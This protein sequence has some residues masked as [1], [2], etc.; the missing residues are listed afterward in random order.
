MRQYTKKEPSQENDKDEDLIAFNCYIYL[1]RLIKVIV[2]KMYAHNL[3]IKGEVKNFYRAVGC[4][5]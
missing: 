1:R 2:S 5:G 3:Y 4:S